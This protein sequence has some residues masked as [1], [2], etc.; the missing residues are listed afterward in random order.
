MTCTLPTDASP[1][2]TLWHIW[3]N[4]WRKNEKKIDHHSA[5][6]SANIYVNKAIG[7]HTDAK[8][9]EGQ[10]TL[11]IYGSAPHSVELKLVK[12]VYDQELF[13][14]RHGT[15]KNTINNTKKKTR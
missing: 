14:G 2:L 9:M 11:C 15:G 10:S 12:L 6:P 13:I 7:T 4:K 1:H 8:L 3:A 5:P